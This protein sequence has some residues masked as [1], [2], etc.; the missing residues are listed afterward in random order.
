MAESDSGRCRGRRP[1]SWLHGI[2]WSRAEAITIMARDSQLSKRCTT[3]TDLVLAG[4]V[5]IHPRRSLRMY[6][7]EDLEEEEEEDFSCCFK[8]ADLISDGAEKL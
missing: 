1:I 8:T 6:H 2:C 7:Y 5:M 4:G 3:K